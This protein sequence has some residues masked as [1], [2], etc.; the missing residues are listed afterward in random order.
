VAEYIGAGTPARVSSSRGTA[1]ARAWERWGSGPAPF[2]QRD[3]RL[4]EWESHYRRVLQIGDVVAGAVAAT[5]AYLA[6]FGLELSPVFF[7]ALVA[8]ALWLSALH[9]HG[10]YHLNRLGV[11]SDEYRAVARA[12][13]ATFVGVAV[14]SFLLHA[15]FARTFVVTMIS[16]CFAGSLG[17]H[18]VMRTRLYRRRLAGADLR[19]TLVVGRADACAAIIREMNA[20]PASGYRVVGVCVVSAE[21]LSDSEIEGV[22]VLGSIDA[23]I[24][25]VDRLGV[26]VVAV[27]S[28]PDLAGQPLRRLGWALAER[29]VDLVVSPGIVEVAGPRLSLRPAAGLSLLHVERPSDSLFR[30]TTKRLMDALLAGILVLFA[31]PIGLLVALLIKLDNPGPVF[32]SQERVGAHGRPF[33]MIKFR[34]MV[35]DAEARK[36][37]IEGGNELNEVLFKKKV[38][39]R[40]TRVGRVIRRLSIDELPQ[41]LN[42]IRGDMSLVGPR[43]PLPREV[44][45][46]E[47]DAMQ[48]LRVRPGLTGLWQISGRSDL[49]WEQSL[50]LDLWHVDNWSPMLDLQIL[51]RTGRAVLRGAGAY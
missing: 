32:F 27:A 30:L 19:D 3:Q 38:D 9:A 35:V 15:T 14:A 44:E 29:H 12:A 6:R 8:P 26:E 43:P 7:V 11:G 36:E 45:L 40:V 4:P 33:R 39:P 42:V 10:A 48:R 31:L 34:S 18:W 25:S 2:P 24:S 1:R 46:Y 37:Q 13:L 49:T 50:R 17:V 23:A 5:A 20:A 47:D 51:A 21:D 41:L 22:A 16:L 28:H